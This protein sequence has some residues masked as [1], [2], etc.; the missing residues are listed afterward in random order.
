[1]S[2]YFKIEKKVGPVPDWVAA[3]DA[4]RRVQA[5][6]VNEGEEGGERDYSGVKP[7][8]HPPIYPASEAQLRY[9]DSLLKKAGKAPLSPQERGSLSKAGASEVID[10]ARASLGIVDRPQPR[11]PSKAR[12]QKLTGK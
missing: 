3:A 9:V 2:R 10:H 7:A 8:S 11:L 1:M 6:R 4:H 12:V 5:P